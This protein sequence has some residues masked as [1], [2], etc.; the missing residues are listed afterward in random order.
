MRESISN[1]R[2]P[3]TKST[4]TLVADSGSYVMCSSSSNLLGSKLEEANKRSENRFHPLSPQL[5]F[6][7]WKEMEL[8]GKS[9]RLF[10]SRVK[11]FEDALVLS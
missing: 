2:S 4:I 3:G 10:L 1:L 9:E 11:C 8:E 6:R 7:P 5:W